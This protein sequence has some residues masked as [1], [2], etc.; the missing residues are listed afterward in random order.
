MDDK[1]FNRL[2]EATLARIE[3][4]LEASGGDIDFQLAAGGVVIA[5]NRVSLAI[6]AH[7]NAVT[8]NAH[9]HQRVTY[10]VG[11]AR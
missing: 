2:A 7:G 10:R 4:A 1:E 9:L 8:G 6:A 11:A 3:H 5:G